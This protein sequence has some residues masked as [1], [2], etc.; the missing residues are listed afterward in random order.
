MIYHSKNGVLN[1][2]VYLKVYRTV[3]YP[4]RREVTRPCTLDE[5]GRRSRDTYTRH[6]HMRFGFPIIP[7]PQ[8]KKRQ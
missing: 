8:T 5:G 2:M 1:P 4:Q 3:Y 7:F 6:A